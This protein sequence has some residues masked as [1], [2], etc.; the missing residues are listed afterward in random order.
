MQKYIA[1]CGIASRRAAEKMIECGRVSVNGDI[2][3]FMGFIIDPDKDVVEIDGE[4]IRPEHKKYYIML[5]KPKNYVTTVKDD[6]GRPTVM[7]LI[8]DIN[9]RMYPVGRLDFDTSGLLIMTNDGEFANM[10]MH[11]SHEI[12]KAYIAKVAHP[13]TNDQLNMLRRGV[14]ID[15]VITAPAKAENI[16]NA[17][18]GAEVKITIHEGKNR[19]V[20]KML[21]EVGADVMS[22]KRISVGSLTLG[23]LP[24]GKWRHL[25]EAEINKLRRKKHDKSKRI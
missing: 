20:R 11:P 6:F 8:K 7:E 4:E 16:L 21:A 17:K 5:N 3:D 14:S 12:N 2:V 18:Y 24:T 13:L 25:S 23:N 9:A 19:Q 10:V 15:G 22:L 1:E